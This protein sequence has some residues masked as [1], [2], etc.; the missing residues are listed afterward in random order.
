MR[1]FTRKDFRLVVDPMVFTIKAFKELDKRDRTKDKVQLEKELS[2]IYFVFDPR[3]DLQYI[4]D[5]GDRID[6]ARE[7]LGLGDKFKMDEVL[8]KAIEVYLSMT[9][10]A[11]SLL[12]K[13]IK[14]GV[15]KL[16]IYLRDAEVD[17]STFDKYTRSL[18][19]LIPL[20]Q[21]ISE[22]EMTVIREI[23]ELGELRGNKQQTI[24]DKGFNAMFK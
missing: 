18:K 9:E 17:N 1:L 16:R 14:V 20:S 23:E 19:E 7:I 15:E 12:L 13:D 2:F 22:A 4:V 8:V 10:T 6:K 21:K 5:V 24:L 3:S 11:S